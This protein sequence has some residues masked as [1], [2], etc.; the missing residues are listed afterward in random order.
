[1]A[2]MNWD[3]VRRETRM[4]RYGKEP[5]H[6]PRDVDLCTSHPVTSASTNRK[7]G[8]GAQSQRFAAMKPAQS[9]QAATAVR[10]P[11]CLA[12]V[13]PRNLQKHKAKE[14]GTRTETKRVATKSLSKPD[15]VTLP[16]KQSMLARGRADTIRHLTS[17]IQHLLFKDLLDSP[18][19]NQFLILTA[20]I[21]TRQTLLR[22]LFLDDQETYKRLVSELRAARAPEDSHMTCPPK[23]PPAENKMRLPVK[24]NRRD[25]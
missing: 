11:F 21:R 6:S 8:E 23:N 12:L 3:K 22:E 1:M 25:A 5:L 19:T 18:M 15:T 13:A 24:Q 4:A 10:C 16:A 14:H 2:R 9:K 20:L 7:P 17:K